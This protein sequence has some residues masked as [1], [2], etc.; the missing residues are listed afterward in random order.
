[1]SMSKTKR[2]GGRRVGFYDMEEE[3]EKRAEFIIQCQAMNENCEMTVKINDYEK[4][5][6]KKI[7]EGKR[8]HLKVT[9]SLDSLGL[10][11]TVTVINKT[12]DM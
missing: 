3:P 4:Y 6:K 2:R 8:T 9:I 10:N 5:T 12:E 11:N 1:M 7:Y